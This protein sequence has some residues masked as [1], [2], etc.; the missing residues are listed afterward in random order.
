ME[1][2][3]TAET[4][5]RTADPRQPRAVRTREQ[6][7]AATRRVAAADG[8][9]AVT[10]TR[11]A[12]ETGISVGALYRYFENR[13]QL[14]LAAYD[15]AVGELVGHF[16]A[17]VPMV[18][19][20][21]EAESAAK[22]A[23]SAFLAAAGNTPGLGMLLR[24]ARRIRPLADEARVH[25]DI[26]VNSVLMPVALRFASPDAAKLPGR[27]QV[28]LSGLSTLTDLY[29]VNDDPEVKSHIRRELEAY[30]L[31]ALKRLAA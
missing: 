14:L 18:Q 13:D 22:L 16:S 20:V 7:V 3:P 4:V 12:A 30:A 8:V 11:I 1:T 17:M 15:E 23:L 27:M 31:F 6:V 24:E 9:D 10:T 26:I 28:L 29:L 5:R 19:S 25:A 21:P 2:Q